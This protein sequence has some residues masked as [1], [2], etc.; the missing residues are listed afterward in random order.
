MPFLNQKHYAVPRSRVLENMTKRNGFRHVIFNA[1]GDKYSGEW[2]NDKKAGKG[3]TITR[4][5]ELYEGDMENNYRHGF[6]VLAQNIPSTN[7]YRLFYRGYWKNGKMHGHGLRI[8]SDGSFYIGEFRN[9]KRQ[10]H[11][12]QR[13]PDGA[14]FD[15]EFKNDVKEG[16]GI[17]VRA[18]GNRYE[19]EWHNDLKHG[20]G[21]F[22]HLG[23]G[24][25]Q[26]GVWSNDFCVCSQISELDYK[27]S[28]VAP[29]P[30]AIPPIRDR[31]KQLSLPEGL[32]PY[33]DMIIN[34]VEP[35]IG[36]SMEMG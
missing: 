33:E 14:F 21:L 15:G 2:K 9:G 4:N 24:K 3:V 18:D 35:V 13:Y 12:Q 19:G 1:L 22:F 34:N 7:A 36:K 29:T 16:L 8:Y 32:D 26:D 17:F 10:E 31:A 6:G 20:K 5:G 27:Q 23:S 25:L 11:G 28:C 30:C